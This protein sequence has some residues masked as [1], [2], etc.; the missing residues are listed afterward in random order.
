MASRRWVAWFDEP[1]ADGTIDQTWRFFRF[2]WR[3]GEWLIRQLK[4]RRL[5]IYPADHPGDPRGYLGRNGGWITLVSIAHLRAG[6]P[7]VGFVDV[8]GSEDAQ[9]YELRDGGIY[10]FDPVRGRN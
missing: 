4:R 6:R 2:R 5:A 9:L 1:R 8:T 10:P 7:A 3:A